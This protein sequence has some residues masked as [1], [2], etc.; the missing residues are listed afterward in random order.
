MTKMEGMSQTKTT[1]KIVS[2]T[3]GKLE[4]QETA[5]PSGSRT[6]HAKITA[7]VEA[8]IVEISL[9]YPD[10]G[11]K[12]LLPLLQHEELN[13]SA[14]SV[15][16][17]LKRHDMQTRAL[18]L[19][20][21]EEQRMAESP[22]RATETSSA[23]ARPIG[24]QVDEPKPVDK[25]ISERKLPP[26]SLSVANLPAKA[27]GWSRTFFFAINSLLLVLIGYLGI[28]AVRSLQQ[29]E[30]EPAA[31]IPIPP[32]PG[33]VVAEIE[34][35]LQPV[36]AY[37]TIK[38]RNLF[39]LS[40]ANAPTHQKDIVLE[41]VAVAKVDLGLNLMGTV[42]VNDSALSLAVV[43]NQQ[44]E[45]IKTY[46]EGDKAGTVLIKKILRNRVVLATTHGDQLLTVEPE[47]FR[48]HR[49]SLPSL[50]GD[51]Q[52]PRH[53]IESFSSDS[54]L[55]ERTV[56]RIR[57]IYFER[58]EVEFSLA[59]VDRLMQQIRISPYK[60]GDHPSGFRLGNIPRDNVLRKMGFR[61]RD[62]IKEVNDQD[63]TGTEQAADF[64]AKLL[65]GGELTV[66]LKR[67]RKTRRI[68]IVVE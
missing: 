30:L 10:F 14:S 1:L 34:S 45:E 44:T 11:A 19:S 33:M 60:L 3:S 65:E 29:A 49:G 39:N 41:N 37:Q 7:E 20:K 53:T 16:R 58:D 59:D 24:S 46:H 23:F 22:S 66:E 35:N 40:I 27:S 17:I 54:T 26:R 51:V 67:R 57:T 47:D 25:D 42:I 6:S 36:S 52:Y 55:S 56:P 64:F 43:Q 9:Q 13:V 48:E 38:A 61:S 15:Y 68:K 21:I 12:R 63:I 18:R 28:G 5:A 50:P 31:L 62:I 32:P 4:E 2:T 8:H